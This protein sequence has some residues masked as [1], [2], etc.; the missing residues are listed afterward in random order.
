M[1]N[2]RKDMEYIKQHSANGDKIMNIMRFVNKETLKE[3]HRKQ[4]QGKATGVDK[5]DKEEYSLNLEEN[6]ERLLNQMKTLS[7]KP[8]PVKR[9]YIPKGN[10]KMRPLGIPSYEDKLVQGAMAEILKA[11]YEPKFLKISYGFITN[12]NCHQAIKEI[13]DKI[14][15]KKVNYVIEADIKGF[16]DNVNHEIL[17]KFL[18]KDI[19]DE[20][21]LRYVKRFLISGYMEE[22]KFYESDRGTPQGGLISPILANVYLHNVLDL[23]FEKEIKPRLKGE[24]YLIRYAD[25][26]IIMCQNKEDADKIYKVLPKRFKKYDL[27]LEP[28]KTKIIPFGRFKGTKET[29][30][31]LGFTHFNK[32]GRNGKYTVGHRIAKKKKRQKLDNIKS[33]LKEHMHDNLDEFIDKLNR[34]LVGMYNYYG[35]NNMLKE[36]YKIYNYCVKMG[37]KVLTRRSQRNNLNWLTYLKLVKEVYP[38]KQPK[39][40]VNIWCYNI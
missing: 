39:I 11:I 8:L 15:F 34:K 38:I 20:T 21:F 26:F 13:N 31:F 17:M 36:L 5:M 12:R 27:E 10:G 35:I 33:F 7:Y 37:Y 1:A 19:K 29:F 24:A 40:K 18:E 32:I 30:D 4:T 16:F 23:W 22:M 28:N 9:V 6:I 2:E 14:M 3:Q 25:D